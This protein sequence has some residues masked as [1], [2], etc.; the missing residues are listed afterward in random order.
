MSKVI[1]LMGVSGSGKTTIGKL[2]SEQIDIP[3]FDA[4]NFHP[5][6]NIEKMS[7]GNSLND[8]DRFP[9]LKVLHK[10][11][12]DE[13]QRKGIILSCS[14]L[15]E[16]Y[17]EILTSGIENV[18]WFYLKGDFQ[19]IK[20]RLES[21]ED[22]FM[23]SDL[24]QSQF[25]C[26]ETPNYGTT[27]GISKEPTQII[28]IIKSTMELSS[29]GIVGLGVMGKS[30]AINM[31]NKNIT[32]SVY[33]RETSEE[34]GIVKRFLEEQS[35]K[36]VRGFTEIENFVMSLAKP[37]K[38]LMMVKAGD[39]TDT[40]IES[41]LPFLEAGDILIDGGNSHYKNTA[42]RELYVKE[43]GIS[44]IGMGVSGG[45]E[46]A[47]K[48]PSLMPGGTIESYKHVSEFLETIAAKDEEG[49]SCCNFI[50]PSGA[51]HFVKMVHNGIEYGDM[52]LLA[53]LYDVLSKFMDYQEISNVFFNWNKGDLGSYLLEITAKILKE[54]D[55]SEYVLDQILDKAGNKGTGSWSSVAALQLGI[56]TTIKTAAVN[57]R[58]TSSYKE[59]RKRLSVFNTSEREY[60]SIEID[61]LAQAYDFA[62]TVNLHQG[63][64]L[65]KIASESYN[66]NLNLGEI[67]RVWSNGC[68]IKSEKIKEYS[69][70]LQNVDTLLEEER[71]V[72][73]LY[74]NE[75]AITKVIAYALTYRIQI[76]CFYEAYNYWIAMTTEKSSANLIQAQRDFF[77]AH[78]F[79]KVNADTEEFVHYNWS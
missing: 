74:K 37:R 70:V 67:C 10:K 24:L 69:K 21:R 53:E 34:Q 23:K 22:H 26:L 7:N 13:K 76:P 45:E 32:L 77:G 41:L 62:R 61:V 58:Y 16:S 40:V 3:F 51:G 79:Q 36:E 65:I 19:L 78:R 44:F 29:F 52:Q 57:A 17:R 2:L 73:Q 11:I 39:V 31:L 46:G 6:S 71:I 15:K 38:I 14:A 27:I 64:Q 28:E 49:K 25:D 1:I 59:E 20:S 50:G 75:K 66:W 60:E 55:G 56:P 4:D 35:H 30:L 8:E 42:R 33:N 9:W 72:L 54:K 18:H 47:L 48:G 12:L 43:K 68:I 5:K 63:L